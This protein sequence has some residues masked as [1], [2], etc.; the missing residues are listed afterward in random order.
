M[1]SPELRVKA[2]YEH[3]K[4][5]LPQ[6]VPWRELAYAFFLRGDQVALFRL[7]SVAS[8]EQAEWAR[9]SEMIRAKKIE[10][11]MIVLRCLEPPHGRAPATGNPRASELLAVHLSADGFRDYH[12]FTVR[13]DR[14]N[15]ELSENEVS[16]QRPFP[17]AMIL[18]FQPW[19]Y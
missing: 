16:A 14:D 18:G 4:P 6:F 5:S 11:T 17:E 1:F 10:A 13:R 8:N 19:A 3:L 2:L 15:V 9:L 7:F 12:E